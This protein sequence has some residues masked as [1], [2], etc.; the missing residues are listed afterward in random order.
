MILLLRCLNSIYRTMIAGLPF[1][2]K[3]RKT[4]L[5]EGFGINPYDPCVTN[6][7]VN[8]K[9]QTMC[10]HVDNFK[11][12]HRDIRVNKRFILVLKEDYESI[13]EDGSG[14]ITM[15]R[16]KVYDDLGMKLDY[17]NKGLCHITMFDQIKE[18]VEIFK[19]LNPNSN[20]TKASASPSNLFIVRYD[21]P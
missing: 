1:Y 12:S 13:F 2:K 20:G 18:I 21:C 7:M 11:L 8:G 14:Q 4:L 15:C 5:R 6:K 19:D 9:Q 10:W 16:R 17:T 3:F